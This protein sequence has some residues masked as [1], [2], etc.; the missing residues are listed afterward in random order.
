MQGQHT[1]E[2][3]LKIQN[4]VRNLHI[5][6]FR[7]ETIQSVGWFIQNASW[8]KLIPGFQEDIRDRCFIISS[9]CMTCFGDN[10]CVKQNP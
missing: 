4:R 3:N 8:D 7:C 9:S 5:Q 6:R 10:N 2:A 1:M